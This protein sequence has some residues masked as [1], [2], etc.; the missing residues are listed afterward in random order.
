MQNDTRLTAEFKHESMTGSAQ[1]IQPSCLL[2][3]SGD[4]T[5]AAAAAAAAAG[6][7]CQPRLVTGGNWRR[8]LPYSP[9]P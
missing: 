3:C 4:I 5:A 7:T 2:A 8:A 9:T 6:L 1:A